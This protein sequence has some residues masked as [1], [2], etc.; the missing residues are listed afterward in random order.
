M[1]YSIIGWLQARIFSYLIKEDG[2]H[3]PGKLACNHGGSLL[4]LTT[5]CTLLYI[6]VVH[7][8][9]YRLY[10]TIHTGCTLLFIQ[11]VELFICK[12]SEG[13]IYFMFNH[14]DG[15]V[16]F[17]ICVQGSHGQGKVREKWIFFKVRE[18]SGNFENGQGN[19]KNK[20]QHRRRKWGRR[21]RARGPNILSSCL[22]GAAVFFDTPCSCLLYNPDIE[23]LRARFARGCCKT[24][25]SLIIW[26]AVS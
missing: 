24:L 4:K 16:W 8:C 21:G 3:F 14:C 22:F 17:W 7:Y 2:E 25:L 18:K 12:V 10:T 26:N 20:Q 15:F 9:L 5:G 11:V 1:K 23:I 19:L 13:C 6:Q